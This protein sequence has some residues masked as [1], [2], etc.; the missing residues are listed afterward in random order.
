[1]GGIWDGLG[2]ILTLPVVLAPWRMGNGAI[3]PLSLPAG[4]GPTALFGVPLLVLAP[5]R[6]LPA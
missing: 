1:M 6:W 5:A 4:A 2:D 3:Y